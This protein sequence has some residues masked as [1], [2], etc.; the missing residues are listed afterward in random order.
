MKKGGGGD[1]KGD[2]KGGDQ[3]GGGGDDK[4]GGGSK[5]GG[6]GKGKGA[7]G[8]AGGKQGGSQKGGGGQSP[9]TNSKGG[10]SGMGTQDALQE[11]AKANQEHAEKT[12]D[13]ILEKLLEQQENPDPE[14]LRK[15]KWTQDDLKDF[16]NRWTELKGRAESGDD[17]AKR[18]Y[19]RKLKSLGL[20]PKGDRR[21]IRQ[22]ENKIKGLIEDGAVNK[23]SNE[24]ES[25]YK[26]FLRDLNR[27]RDN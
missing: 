10:D 5:G 14:L 17:K 11:R 21:A 19:E 25:D 4:K 7:K 13:L 6:D 26:S 3:K 27:A 2:K 9:S 8:D 22:G 16:V 23:P 24:I 18:K 15:M 1:K 12:T 20:R